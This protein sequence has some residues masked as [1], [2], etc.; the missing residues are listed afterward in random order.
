M[1]YRD[2]AKAQLRV[3]EGWKSK[4]YKDTVGK[5]TAGCGRNLDDVGLHDDEIMLML[6]N[7]LTAAE[8]TA[9]ALFQSF[10]T[11]SDNRK[12]VLL[13]MALN[14]GQERLAGFHDFRAAIAAGDF[15]RASVAMLESRWATQVGARAQRLSKQI[16]EG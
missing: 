3:D 12:A 8:A 16:K 14:L 9:R 5:L 10:D 7:D 13:N 6:D 4:P 11:L 15:D 2:I 1:T